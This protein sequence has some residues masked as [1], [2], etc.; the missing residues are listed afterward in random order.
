M[1]TTR[2]SVLAAAVLTSAVFLGGCSAQPT[3]PND[4]TSDA[5]Q[6]M[7]ADGLANAPS[8]FQQE[9]LAE[10]QKSGEISEA[11]WKEANEQYQSCLTDLGRNVELVYV[12]AQVQ[13]RGEVEADEAIDEASRQKEREEDTACYEKTSMYINEIYAYLHD[14]SAEEEN[15]QL[16]RAVYACLIETKVIP[17]DT[18]FEEFSAEL[19]AGGDTKFSDSNTP[20]DPYDPCWEKVL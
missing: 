15:D 14:D 17:K 16:E 3:A 6:E 10:A 1:N 4:N 11:S 9:V 20:A 19:A 13:I 7:I 12:G 5:L 18:T 2:T 8:D